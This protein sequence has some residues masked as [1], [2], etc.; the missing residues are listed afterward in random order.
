MYTK[1]LTL[2]SFP[3][4]SKE[5]VA[6]NVSEEQ[7]SRMRYFAEKLAWI[8]TCINPMH[9]FSGRTDLKENRDKPRV[10]ATALY[11]TKQALN[12]EVVLTNSLLLYKKLVKILFIFEDT[13]TS[14]FRIFLL[15]IPNRV[16]HL[17]RRW[18]KLS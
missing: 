10:P 1:L 7:V 6:K 14:P 2:E 5:D 15:S 3:K 9:A 11:F 4:V 16:L 8:T 12:N 13:Q 17:L 18:I